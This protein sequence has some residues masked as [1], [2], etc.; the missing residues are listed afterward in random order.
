MVKEAPLP[1]PQGEQSADAWQL[2]QLSHS[3]GNE[4]AK[5]PELTFSPFGPGG[6]IG[7]GGPACPC[8]EQRAREEP[9]QSCGTESPPWFPDPMS[10]AWCTPA[11]EGHSQR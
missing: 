6:P 1:Q 2:Q 4:V 10:P 8:G 5:P 11:L 7:P 3:R 9:G